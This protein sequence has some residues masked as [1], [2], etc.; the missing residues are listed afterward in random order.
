MP[1]LKKKANGAR[2]AWLVAVFYALLLSPL[3][4]W[5]LPSSADDPLLFGGETP[6]PAERYHASQTASQ[7]AARE[8]GA[9][10]DLNPLGNAVQIVD[11]TTTAEDRAAILMRY[12]LY[13]RQPDEMITFQALQRMKP[14]AFDFDPRLYQY[15][16]AFIYLVGAALGVA[17]LL[18]FTTITS[19]IDYYLT[20]PD[21]F[22]HFFVVA[23][24][25]VL[26]FGVGTLVAVWRLALRAGEM[27]AWIAML[28]VA[29][30]PGFISGALEAKPH[31]PG[32]CMTLWAT[33]AALEFRDHGR[34][35]DALRLGLFAGLAAGFVLTG[36]AAGLLWSALLCV[37]VRRKDDVVAVVSSS[38]I[39]TE[40]RWLAGAAAIAVLVYAASNPYVIYNAFFA[41]AALRSNLGNS[42]AMY[43][44]ARVGEGAVN[45]SWLLWEAGG[46]IPVVALLALLL[47]RR[48]GF[49]SMLISAAPG[50]GMLA[51]CCLI[52]AGKPAEFGRFLV[53]PIALMAVGAARLIT[54]AAPRGYQLPAA[55]ALA[56]F[57][58]IGGTGRYLASFY[59]DA[60]RV[61]DTRRLAANWINEHVDE[62]APIGVTREPAPYAIPP[63]DF[64]RRV[65]LLLPRTALRDGDALPEWLV[66]AADAPW[67]FDDAW[68]RSRYEL[69]ATFESRLGRTP[70]TWAN[71]TTLIFRRIANSDQ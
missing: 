27:A 38:K 3:A 1:I 54:A 67:S 71:K 48:D 51:L 28:L 23:R 60:A 13:S 37:G 16:G 8:A 62:N 29:L 70:I 21:A 9:D 53:L 31:L 44:I 39:T 19:N 10:T 18:G 47:T 14:R 25:L 11:L 32:V 15:G 52:G 43:D 30:T 56:L 22:G 5:G 45:V 50:F 36:F 17:S 49:R 6:W 55:I 35:G 41:P 46:V 34:R 66:T 59:V 24:L 69:A 40:L 63:L 7:R 68:W 26:A 65:V 4:W 33:L 20:N 57:V 58:A 61:H 42:T 12:R 64:T 2:H